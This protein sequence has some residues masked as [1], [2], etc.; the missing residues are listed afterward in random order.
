VGLGAIGVLVA[1]RL[2]SWQ[3]SARRVDALSYVLVVGAALPLVV[4]R[5]WP[6]VVLVVTGAV[7]SAY[8]I[9]RYPYGPIVL[10]LMIAIYTV[11]ARLPARRAVVLCGAVLLALLVHVLVRAVGPDGAGALGVFVPGSA[12]VVVPFAVGRV[13]RIGRESAARTRAEQAQRIA[14]EERLRIA[15]EVH[16][17]VGHGLTAI[18]LQA[19]IALHV[20]PKRPEQ[21]ESALLA[22]SRSSG[23]ALDELRATLAVVRSGGDTVAPR[24]PM[25]GLASLDD[26]VARMA[27]AGVAVTLTVTGMRPNLPATV[28]LAGYRI[29]QEALTNVLRHAGTATAAV[30]VAYQVD[31]LSV[32]V[33][34]AGRGVVGELREGQGIAGMR[35]RAAALGG[36][37]T[38]GPRPGG[39]FR[40]HAS[41]PVPT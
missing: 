37:L 26:L 36:V 7:T 18:H 21:A 23:Q 31:G 38:T 1:H 39:G 9:M 34:D 19:E 35:E 22:I 40:V 12:W 8:L 14:Y 20:L 27:D 41:L 32:E 10:S 13:S 24:T 29:V 28:E 16:D 3:H 30:Q 2:G 6:E 15:Q 33:T 25:P 5:R 17:V 11:A 4:R